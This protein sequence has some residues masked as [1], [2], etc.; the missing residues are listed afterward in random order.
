MVGASEL[1]TLP[2]PGPGNSE[3]PVNPDQWVEVE[4]GERPEEVSLERWK[5]SLVATSPWPGPGD[6][7]G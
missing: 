1:F 4:G 3:G 2:W 5:P 7:E 6:S